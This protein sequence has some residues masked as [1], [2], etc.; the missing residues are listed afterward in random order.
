MARPK[1][2]PNKIGAELKEHFL[3]AFHYLQIDE[4]KPFHLN[5]WAQDNP[6]DFYALTSKLFPT[7]INHG[8]QDDNPINH[9]VSVKFVNGNT[10]T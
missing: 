10:D 1:G 6:K 8:G 7:E 2:S 3:K 9:N 5:Q 4:T